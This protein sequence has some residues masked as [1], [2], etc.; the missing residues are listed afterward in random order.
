ME[1]LKI[2][3]YNIAHIGDIY[4]SQPYVRNII[5]SNNEKFD[6][7]IYCEC[8]YFIFKDFPNL[9]KI[10]DYPNIF[11]MFI[12]IDHRDILYY[13]DTQNNILMLNT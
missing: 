6:Y 13:Y 9:K 12:S 8:N 1:K 5:N 7:Y 11:D 4:F 2:I 10:K 3:F